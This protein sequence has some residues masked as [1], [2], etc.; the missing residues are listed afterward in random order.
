MFKHLKR[1][2][3][4]HG[5]LSYKRS[6]SLGQFVVHR[7]LIITVNQMVFIL[8]FYYCSIAIYNGWLMLGYVTIFTSVPVF[9]LILDED[10]DDQTAMQ[11]PALYKTLQKGRSFSF[12]IFLVWTAQSLYQV[13]CG[14]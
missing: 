12:K 4:W 7:G 2:L 8:V 1:L 6:A 14:H 9:T 10:V 13:Q 5:R 11:Y 3:L